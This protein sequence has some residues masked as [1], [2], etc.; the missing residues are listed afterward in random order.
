MSRQARPR[1]RLATPTPGRLKSFRRFGA[2]RSD[3]EPEAVLLAADAVLDISSMVIM[4]ALSSSDCR[5]FLEDDMDKC[6]GSGARSAGSIGSIGAMVSR[7]GVW[8]S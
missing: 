2:W 4:D 1:V 7:V 5:M 3:D 6:E 8:T